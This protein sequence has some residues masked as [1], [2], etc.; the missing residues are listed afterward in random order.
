MSEGMLGAPAVSA[1]VPESVQLQFRQLSSQNLIMIFW[2]T[3]GDPDQS[4]M[5]KFEIYDVK[6]MFCLW[7][8]TKTK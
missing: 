6:P 8:Y 3:R 1:T 5:V 2:V 4:S 7:L